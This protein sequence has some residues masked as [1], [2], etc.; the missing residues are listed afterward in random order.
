MLG[1]GQLE[2][3]RQLNDLLQRL[4]LGL[5]LNTTDS[6]QRANA[7]FAYMQHTIA[8]GTRVFT[9]GMICGAWSQL[10]LGL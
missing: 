1:G 9:N 8:F 2:R 10:G 4:D 6:T 7:W 3:G 5:G